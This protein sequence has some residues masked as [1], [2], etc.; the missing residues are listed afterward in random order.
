MAAVPK[1]ISPSI[2]FT[3]WDDNPEGARDVYRALYDV[4]NGL[5]DAEVV[6]DA[7]TYWI[8]GAFEEVHGQDIQDVDI[9]GFYRVLAFY[10][11]T[12]RY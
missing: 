9:P 12:I 2:Q 1:V 5:S 7:V 10:S 4:L 11:I 6:R 8:T 3:C